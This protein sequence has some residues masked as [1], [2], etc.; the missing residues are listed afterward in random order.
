MSYSLRPYKPTRLLSPWNF[1]GKN[2][3]VAGH[4]LLQGIFLTQVS[5]LCLL[6]P[7][8]WQ[9]DSLPVSHLGS[10]FFIYQFSS[11]FQVMSDYLRPYGLQHSRLPCLSS[12][13]RACSN[14]CPF[15]WWCHSTI[16]S[17]VFP[18]SSCLQSFSALGSYTMSQ[19]FTSSGQSIGVSASA[20]VLPMN[21]WNWSPLGWTGWM[22]L[23]SM[24]LKS[25]LQHHS[26]EASTLWRSAFFIVQLS[27]PYMTTGRTIALTRQTFVS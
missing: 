6:H 13:P 23:Q 26:S 24:S 15:S 17:S 21:I 5:N 2:I 4:F 27:H 20:S 9:E 7:L 10:P 18:I 19:F 12:T 3:K 8:L 11:V 25:L 14:S 1:P 22:S 16:S